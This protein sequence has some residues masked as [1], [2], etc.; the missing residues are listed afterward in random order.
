[1]QLWVVAGPDQRQGEDIKDRICR[2]MLPNNVP[3]AS[4]DKGGFTDFIVSRR[5]EEFLAS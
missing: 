4:V 5:A 3:I 2:E 1:V